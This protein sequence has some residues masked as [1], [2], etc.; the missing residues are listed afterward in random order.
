MS[1]NTR[2]LSKVRTLVHQFKTVV[3]KIEGQRRLKEAIAL[4]ALE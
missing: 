4:E 1:R 2:T 3:E